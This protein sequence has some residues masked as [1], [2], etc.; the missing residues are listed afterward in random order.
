M[1]QRQSLF[2]ICVLCVVILPIFLPCS[3]GEGGQWH[4]NIASGSEFDFLT[5]RLSW[6]K[7]QVN[8]H[9]SSVM[10]RYT[11]LLVFVS[12]GRQDDN[13][14]ISEVY[15]YA[16]LKNWTLKTIVKLDRNSLARKVY[17][18]VGK[19]GGHLVGIWK[20]TWMI[21]QF[22]FKLT[23]TQRYGEKPLEE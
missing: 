9:W 21:I 17:A 16:H 3:W 13:Q 2:K 23:L 20:S 15:W 8:S 4:G 12:V 19:K 10:A 14:A 6:I 11:W 5:K 18:I 1:D 22:R 7:K